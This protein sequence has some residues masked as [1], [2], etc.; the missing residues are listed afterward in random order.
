MTPNLK[1]RKQG[2]GHGKHRRAWSRAELEL[3][4]PLAPSL[5]LSSLHR[6]GSIRLGVRESYTWGLTNH[7]KS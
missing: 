2:T 6:E 3:W 1:L 5:L 7:D 4:H